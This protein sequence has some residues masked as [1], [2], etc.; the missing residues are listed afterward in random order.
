MTRLPSEIRKLLAAGAL[1]AIALVGGCAVH[2]RY[3]DPGHSDYH[4]WSPGESGYYNRWEADTHRRHEDYNRRRAEEQQEYWNW[5]H[6][7]DDRH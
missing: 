2:A 7:H 1:G 4:R 3:Y 5:R 6:G